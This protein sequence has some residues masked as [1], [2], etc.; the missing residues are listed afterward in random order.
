V[1]GDVPARVRPVALLLLAVA[2]AVLPAGGVAHAERLPPPDPPIAG[3]APGW[4]EAPEVS[5]EA[6]VLLDGATGQVLAEERSE[7]RRPVASTVKVLTALTVLD[8]TDPDDVV[9]VGDEVL[10]GGA[11]VG[12]SP[13]DEW[14][15]E[16]LLD[17]LLIRSG[18]DAAEALAAHV[19]GDLDAFVEL[20][21]ED[22]EALGIEDLTLTSVSG[23]DDGNLLSARDLG[24][25]A[26]VAL[27]DDELRPLLGRART[28]LPG[29]GQVVN[30]NE[31]LGAYP[32]AT[33]VKTGY[34]QAAGFSL[35]ASARRDGREL[36]AVVLDADEDPA[37][38]QDAA[39]L[40]DH[41]FDEF[42]SETV[43]ET[44]QL[45]VGGGSHEVEVPDVPVVVP[46]TATLELLLGP[47][48]RPEP[49]TLAVDLEVGG[50][51][52]GEVV[53]EVGEGPEPVSGGAA[54]GRALADGAYAGMRAAT[55]ADAW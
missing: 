42:R 34:T 37:R 21:R 52:L 40:L 53:A 20:M 13:G 8:R 33:G 47:P 15:I 43:S 11:S 9:E 29:L 4:P 55:G 5:A 41:G 39:A 12:L 16:E 25:L 17:G 30:R 35:V 14:T 18:N 28:A 23:L 46:D 6:F 2:L 49:G 44:L 7:E 38:F 22:A 50:E 1:S 45:L 19:A 27:E 31:L 32:G 26:R 54:V 10:V 51:V 3:P 36:I 24:V 48:A